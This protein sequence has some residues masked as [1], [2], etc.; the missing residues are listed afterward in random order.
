MIPLNKI[1][2]VISKL[3]GDNKNNE[4][5][6]TINKISE[7]IYLNYKT[8]QKTI[9]NLEPSKVNVSRFN[10]V[11]LNSDKYFVV[12]LNEFIKLVVVAINKNFMNKLSFLVRNDTIDFE[13]EDSQ[14]G[15]IEFLINNDKSDLWMNL[16]NN[17]WEFVS[18]LAIADNRISFLSIDNAL[19]LNAHLKNGGLSIFIYIINYIDNI[20]ICETESM[21][22][23]KPIISNKEIINWNI[24]DSNI[25]NEEVRIDQHFLNSLINNLKVGKFLDILAIFKKYRY[26]IINAIAQKNSG[27]GSENFASEFAMWWKIK[28]KNPAELY[29]LKDNLIETQLKLTVIKSERDYSKGTLNILNNGG[30]QNIKNEIKNI[31]AE[32]DNYENLINGIN[33][34]DFDTYPEWIEKIP[35]P[36]SF[37]TFLKE[38]YKLN[39]DISLFGFDSMDDRSQIKE[40][41]ETKVNLRDKLRVID[42]HI[43]DNIIGQDQNIGPLT[44]VMKRWFVGL[45][46]NKP[47]GSFLFVGPTG[48]GKT[49]TAKI[50]AKE[51]FNNNLI[52]L[53]MSEYQQS[54]DVSKIIGIAPGYVGYDAGGGL[55]EKVLENPKSVILLDEIEKAHPKVFDLFLQLLD[56]GRL[57]DNKGNVVSFKECLIIATSNACNDL[58]EEFQVSINDSKEASRKDIIQILHKTGSFRKEFLARFTDILK[59]KSLDVKTLGMIFNQKLDLELL[60]FKNLKDFSRNI[61]IELSDINRIKIQNHIISDID[62]SL[63]AR[64]IQRVIQERIT[65]KILDTIVELELG[66]DQTEGD[67]IFNLVYNGSEIEVVEEVVG[68]KEIDTEKVIAEFNK[69]F[70]ELF[71]SDTFDSIDYSK[72]EIKYINERNVYVPGNDMDLRKVIFTKG[73]RAEISPNDFEDLFDIFDIFRYNKYTIIM[74]TLDSREFL[75]GDEDD[76]GAVELLEDGRVA[77]WFRWWK[78]A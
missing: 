16:L 6:D 43:S 5:M 34:D 31:K 58:I 9:I 35:G 21:D 37:C 61:V 2:E 30:I 67:L 33:M 28:L 41:Q 63:G 62:K 4:F 18:K 42:K 25:I 69:K 72:T 10:S 36:E 46:T 44:S 60:H 77:V 22:A 19:E 17:I 29:S 13:E 48:V 71:S 52:V 14:N 57:T 78:E 50:I 7:V 56:E 27:V 54:I 76:W 40:I 45:R 59:F 73:K 75:L 1:S 47:V 49:E 20:H 24:I 8:D 70:Q 15:A 32:I 53:D 38:K 66:N 68:G 39:I 51:L 64:E 74:E 26:E 23:L 55:L 12:S 3:I 65:N 11:S